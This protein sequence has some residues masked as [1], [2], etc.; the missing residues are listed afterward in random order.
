[1]IRW[2]RVLRFL[3]R[4]HLFICDGSGGVSLLIR[5]TG[6]WSGK[7]LNWHKD[8][9]WEVKAVGVILTKSSTVRWLAIRI[10]D[11]HHM[12]KTPQCL[13]KRPHFWYILQRPMFTHDTRLWFHG[14]N[15]MMD[16]VL[17]KLMEW[18]SLD[19]YHDFVE[20]EFSM[21]RLNT[22]EHWVCVELFSNE[23]TQSKLRVAKT[24]STR[25]Y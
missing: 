7:S 23:N 22:A 6:N 17:K 11:T 18:A 16:M 24:S 20:F 15:A 21:L 13:K 14:R 5:S 12:S 3:E 19:C 8:L 25:H 9:F 2:K 1:M 4:K 10:W